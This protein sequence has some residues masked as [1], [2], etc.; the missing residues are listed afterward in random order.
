MAHVK[1]QP[2][3]AIMLTASGTRVQIAFL[4]M[5]TKAPLFN[6]KTKANFAKI[7]ECS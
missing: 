2:A 3:K 7:S 1:Q 4:A 6:S 5:E